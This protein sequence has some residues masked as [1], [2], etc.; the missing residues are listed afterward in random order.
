MFDRAAN[1]S[2]NQII[3]YKCDH[4]EKWLVLNGI[5]PG[6]PEVRPCFLCC[7]TDEVYKISKSPML[8]DNIED[9]NLDHSPK[10]LRLLQFNKHG[11]LLG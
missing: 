6:A 8:L 11:I 3:N 4:T 7:Q 5:A 9:M 2:N 10:I 1:L